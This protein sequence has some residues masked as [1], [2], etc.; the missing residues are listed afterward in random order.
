VPAEGTPI[1]F[2]HGNSVHRSAERAVD[3]RPMHAW[4]FYDDAAAEA[5][6]FAREAV[7]ALR[8]LDVTTKRVGVD[9][10]G[11]PGFLALR[12]AGLSLVDSSPITQ[13]AR[14]IK[15]PEET[16]AFR[17]TGALVV[18][19]LSAMRE[20]LRPGVAERELL[21]VYASEAISRGAEYLATNTLCSGPNTNPWRAEATARR[22]EAGDLVY[23]DTDTVG[24][25][26]SFFCVSR[27]FVCGDAAPTAAQREL[28]RIAHDWLEGTIACVRP[29]LAC[30]ELA[31]EAPSIPDRFHAQ[32]YEVM[33]HSVGLE[34]DS[35]SVAHPGDPQPN[36]DREI[37]PGMALVVECYLGEVGAR[38]G[39]KLGE[40]ILVTDEGTER[41]APFPFEDALLT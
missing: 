16:A 5:R 10:L 2:E 41:L 3:V 30:G 35:P 19:A 37:R 8:E 4:E 13:E 32:R 20:A 38:E 11:T 28:Y 40:E 12:E 14:E 23:V 33:L 15:T 21:A 18:D 17:E 1:L 9:R 29:G 6:A 34:E 26:G 7:A 39:I 31:A 36:P 22:I 24:I 25:E 27:A